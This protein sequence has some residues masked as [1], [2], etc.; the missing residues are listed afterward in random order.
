MQW[1]KVCHNKLITLCNQE[2]LC[3]EKNKD[4]NHNMSTI[5]PLYLKIHGKFYTASIEKFLLKRYTLERIFIFYLKKK[6]T[7]TEFKEKILLTEF[8]Q[9][10]NHHIIP[11]LNFI[12]IPYLNFPT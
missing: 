9:K 10:K 12:Q 3:T 4:N 7:F 5:H 2:M 1:T 8:M 6:K 11:C